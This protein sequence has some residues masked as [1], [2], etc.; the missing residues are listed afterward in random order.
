MEEHPLVGLADVEDLAYLAR[1]SPFHVSQG[2]DLALA[3][4][5][6]GEHRPQTVH[7][8]A[9]GQAVVNVVDPARWWVTPRAIRAEAGGVDG[10]PASGLVGGPPLPLSHGT[11][12]I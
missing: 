10:G 9:R 7:D 12:P 2:N 5:Q 8:L 11:G 3:G 4:R 6:L 1:R